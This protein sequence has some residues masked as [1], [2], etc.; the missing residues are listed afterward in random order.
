MT[1]ELK[2]VSWSAAASALSEIRREV[3][4]EE[5]LVPEELE[6][7]GL[8]A[9]CRHVLATET[10]TGTAVG[11]GRLV[12]DGQIGRMAIRKAW[13][14]QGIGR[15]ILQQLI[16]LARRDGHHAVFL[17]AQCY[18]VAFYQQAGFT[19]EGEAFMDAGIP[20]VMMRLKL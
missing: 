2:A 3:F 7:D 19:A 11:T 1:I 12:P 4:I 13:R 14:R 20:H 6:W 18:A 10:T 8:D 15:Q 5:Q 16:E 17:H 9:D